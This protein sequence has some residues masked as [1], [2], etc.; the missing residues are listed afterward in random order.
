MNYT[1][2]PAFNGL[3][4]EESYVLDIEVHPG[5]VTFTLDLVLTPEHPQYSGPQSGEQYC[6]RRGNLLF[7]GVENFT[8]TGQGAPPAID[9]TGEVDYGTV[10]F[11]IHNHA[12]YCLEGSWGRIQLTARD[13]EVN[14]AVLS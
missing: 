2:L 11:F 1:D 8:W 3:F 5:M 13:V 12:G 4:M 10:E 7:S 6:Y 9:A 14:L